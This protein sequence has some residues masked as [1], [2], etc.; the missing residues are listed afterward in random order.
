MKQSQSLT[1]HLPLL[2]NLHFPPS[3]LYCVRLPKR[4]SL[5]LN[6]RDKA[7][8]RPLALLT[9]CH[10]FKSLVIFLLHFGCKCMSEHMW[11]M[12]N[13]AQ[14]ILH[15]HQPCT[16]WAAKTSC[17]PICLQKGNPFFKNEGLGNCLSSYLNIR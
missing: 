7:Q 1:H 3:L 14:Q 13:A 2:K 8:L 17:C 5:T 4:C 9:F 12:R 16:V 11:L 15:N 6:S 10:V